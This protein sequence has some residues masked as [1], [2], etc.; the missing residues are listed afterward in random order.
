[1]DYGVRLAWVQPQY[2]ASEQ[3]S[4]FVPTAW[5]A[6]QAPRLYYPTIVNGVR[7]GYD[8]IT[9]TT[10]PAANIGYIVPNSGNINNGIEQGG[11]NGFT[12]YLQN[13][14]G[15]AWGPR[16]GLA[17]D[18]F[19]DHKT[20]IRTGFG[21]YYDRFQ[22]NRVFDFVRN[23]P[24]GLQPTLTYGLMQNINPSNALLSPPSEYA[25]DPTGKIP[26]SYNFTFGLQRSL[27]SMIALDVAYVGNLTR[28]LQDDRNLNYIPYGTTFLAQNQDPTL[29]PSTIPGADALLQQFVAPYRGISDSIALYEG[30][31]T[32]NYNALQVSA[33]RRVGHLFLGVNY[34]WSKNL[35]TAT[36]DT[37]Y[38]RADQFTHMAYYGPSGNDR[39][40]AFVMNY[41]YTLPTLRGAN[42]I[43]KSVLGG[44]QVS[45]VTTFMSGA[46]YNP[47][48]SVSTGGGNQNITGSYTEG[49]R[50]KLLCNPMTGNS[51]PYNRLNASCF[52][53]PSVGSIGLESGYDYLTGPGINNWDL[54]LMKEFS[55][56]EKVHIQLRGDA[57]NVWNHTQFSGTNASLTASTLIGA[58]TNLAEVNGALN[59][60]TGFGS[61]SGAR[62]PRILMT[63][64]RI[65]F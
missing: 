14:P 10:V 9:N 28:H 33:N 11:V 29:A 38:V 46:P 62:D 32:G 35:T 21:I 55:I 37:S 15:L 48:F 47:G 36:S 6:S 1:M 26:S 17:Y 12:K 63:M 65:R 19:G 23:P 18:V 8:A 7:V 39:R 53:L 27:P 30:G 51:D 20:V 40:Q 45:G 5:Q 24:L 25:A 42:G 16:L 49:A 13:S 64:I 60:K 4:T 22:G 34:T 54:S 61:V 59:N 31:A 2:D 57:F 41:V 52:A 43:E 44:W 3:A 56:K 50:L 58:F